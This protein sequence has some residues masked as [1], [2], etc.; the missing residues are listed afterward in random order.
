MKKQQLWDRYISVALK[1]SSRESPN[2]REYTA[3]LYWPHV[4]GLYALGFCGDTI[5]GRGMIQQFGDGAAKYI[6]DILGFHVFVN[7]LCLT[8]L[9]LPFVK[10]LII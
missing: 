7:A 4:K 2:R 8:L 3:C 5:F 9:N 1:S 10:T 6:I